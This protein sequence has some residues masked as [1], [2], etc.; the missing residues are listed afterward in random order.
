MN[1]DLQCGKKH[2]GKSTNLNGIHSS[3][4]FKLTN[5]FQFKAH[6][7]TISYVIVDSRAQNWNKL[8]NWN[9]IKEYIYPSMVH[10]D[11][12][13]LFQKFKLPQN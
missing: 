9:S 5:V 13:V 12:Y 6:G 7:S 8:V 4:S 3:V 10:G 1:K 2:A 11:I